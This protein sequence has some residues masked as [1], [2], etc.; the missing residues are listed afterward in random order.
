MLALGT[1]ALLEHPDQLAAL[2]EH[3]ELLDGAIEELLRYLSIAHHGLM[4]TT[5]EDVEI[6]G[7]VIPAESLVIISVSEANRDP[8]HYDTP[9]ELDVSRPRRAHLAFGHGIHQC[10]GR[11][12]AR[13]ELIVG[14]TELLRRL[15]GLRFAIP[16]DE[17]PLRD[18][19]IVYGVQSLPVAW[20]AS[21]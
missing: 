17:V 19:M 18:E 7:Q 5:T 10:V 6:A 8:R 2:R 21:P 12:L 4:R 9:A 16:A 20:D 3:P 15:H 11:Q 1:F 14:F 13:S